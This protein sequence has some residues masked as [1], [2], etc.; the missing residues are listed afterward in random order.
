MIILQL[1]KSMTWV[2]RGYMAIK[3]TAKIKVTFLCRI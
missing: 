1:F 3:N 2:M